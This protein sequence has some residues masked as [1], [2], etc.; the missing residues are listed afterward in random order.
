MATRTLSKEDLKEIEEAF[1]RERP[2]WARLEKERQQRAKRAQKADE[3]RMAKIAAQRKAM[4]GRSVVP[5]TK[6]KLD[7]P[8][9]KKSDNLWGNDPSGLSGPGKQISG[10]RGVSRS[11]M[12]RAPIEPH[13]TVKKTQGKSRIQPGSLREKVLKALD[14]SGGKAQVN[15][16][17][18][19]LKLAPLKGVLSKLRDAGWVEVT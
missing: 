4:K 12:P 10:I 15:D 19:V 7:L 14:I 16:L 5:K 6:P 17:T 8:K 2:E 9:G 11:R 13:M 1:E 3:E 18:V